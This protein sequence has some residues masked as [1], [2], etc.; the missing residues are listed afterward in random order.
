MRKIQN[1]YKLQVVLSTNQKKQLLG[2]EKMHYV[3]CL[4][5]LYNSL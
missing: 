1:L 5:L 2:H 3:V 4:K